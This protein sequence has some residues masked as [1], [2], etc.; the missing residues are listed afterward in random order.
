VSGIAGK[1]YLDP[2]DRLCGRK[3][4]PEL[5]TVLAQWNGA[6]PRNVLVEYQDGSQAVIPF[7]RRLRKADGARCVAC[8]AEIGTC[9]C[10]PPP[11]EFRRLGF[12]GLFTA[13]SDASAEA[14]DIW[15]PKMP[16]LL[17]DQNWL[18]LRADRER[19]VITLVRKDAA[20]IVEAFTRPGG[21][22]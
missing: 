11:E 21:A 8:A 14:L 6:G 20:A 5:V 18:A 13:E 22:R 17:P 7:S 1:R 16:C 3:D 9:D 2:G 4:P 15:E 12:S 19:G 10:Q